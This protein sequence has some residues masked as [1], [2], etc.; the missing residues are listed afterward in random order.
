MPCRYHRAFEGVLLSFHNLSLPEGVGVIRDEQPYLNLVVEFDV[1]RCNPR[2]TAL[3]G[4]VS[5]D[6]FSGACRA[7]ASDP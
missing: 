1:G 6:V 5:A 4:A 7:F 3:V 2:V